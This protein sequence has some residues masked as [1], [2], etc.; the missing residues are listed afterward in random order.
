MRGNAG[1]RTMGVAGARARN[2]TITCL[3]SILCIGWL[4][5]TAHGTLDF[6]GR[7][8]GTDFSNVWTAGRMTLDGKASHV[9]SW[10]EHFAVQRAVHGSAS[11]DLF[12]SGT[13]RPLSSSS[14]RPSQVFR[15]CRR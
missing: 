14:R 5:A 8:L 10:P 9:W 15:T 13:I 1:K 3:V 7:P 6:L 2:L 11:V 12:R 4:F